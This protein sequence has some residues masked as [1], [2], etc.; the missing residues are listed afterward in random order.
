MN[1][2]S[3]ENRKIIRE[4]SKLF[5]VDEKDVPKTLKRIKDEVKEM[6]RKIK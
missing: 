6:E 5:K 1:Q 2:N 4:L 3:I